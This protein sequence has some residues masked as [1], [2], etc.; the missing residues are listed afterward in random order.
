LTITKP[1]SVLTRRA[2]STSQNET[3][4]RRQTET[5]T[6]TNKGHTKDDYVSDEKKNATSIT[7]FPIS[8]KPMLATAV[9]EPFNDKRWVFE[10]KWDGVRSIFFW[11]KTKGI[12]KIQSRS[13]KDITHRYPELIRPLKSAIRCKESIILDGEIVYWIKTVLQVFKTIREG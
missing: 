13:G 12:F 2:V 5:M 10:I 3:G 7:Q 9:D 11:H 6:I 4:D 1:E 8:V